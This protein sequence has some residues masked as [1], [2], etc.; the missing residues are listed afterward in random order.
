MVIHA[1]YNRLRSFLSCRRVLGRSHPVE[2]LI[3]QMIEIFE[4][5]SIS[6]DDVLRTYDLWDSLSVISLVAAVDEDYGV[7]LDADDLTD[8]VTASDLFAFVE[9]RRTA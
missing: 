3:E 5:D 1:G 6:P 8:I 7:T 9:A 4:V 2:K